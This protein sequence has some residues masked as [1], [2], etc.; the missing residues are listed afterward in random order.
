M[1][2]NAPQVDDVLGDV[3]V[4]EELV[5]CVAR[6]GR[7]L[8]FAAGEGSSFFLTQNR[9]EQV[10]NKNLRAEVSSLTVSGILTISSATSA[11][12]WV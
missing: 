9:A 2:K 7:P 8:Y 4:K 11:L 10:N 5:G 12:G 1:K 6:C 3:V